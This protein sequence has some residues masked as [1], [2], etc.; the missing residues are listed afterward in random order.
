MADQFDHLG[1]RKTNIGQEVSV[2]TSVP[3]ATFRALER[4]TL[5]S[6]TVDSRTFDPTV[7]ALE[8]SVWDKGTGEQSALRPD[9]QFDPATMSLEPVEQP[10]P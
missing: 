5:K 1:Y 7:H 4:S 8:V 6:V 9:Q 3:V 2:G 10:A